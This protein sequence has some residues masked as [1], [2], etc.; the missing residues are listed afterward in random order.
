MKAL[1]KPA[2][3]SAVICALSIFVLTIYLKMS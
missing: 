3:V 2:V 1:N